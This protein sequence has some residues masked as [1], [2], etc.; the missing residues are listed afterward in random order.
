M[1]NI[2][3]T[4]I[5]AGLAPFTTDDTYATHYEDYGQ[6]GY[7]AVATIAAR[8]AIPTPRLKTGMLVHVA[9]DDTTYRLKSDNTWEATLITT[10]D[11]LDSKAEASTTYTKAEVNSLMI[12]IERL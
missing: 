8:D 6:G 1:S 5:G 12:Q 9:A 2:N 10:Q 4:N 11:K 7:R 3:G